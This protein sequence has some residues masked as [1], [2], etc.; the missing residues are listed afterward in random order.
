MTRQG[1]E[2]LILQGLTCP[3]EDAAF[4]LESWG[5]VQGAGQRQKRTQ[6]QAHRRP[7]VSV[8]GIGLQGGAEVGGCGMRLIW[9][10][11]PGLVPVWPFFWPFTHAEAS[12]SPLSL[13]PHLSQAGPFNLRTCLAEPL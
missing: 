6:L 9:V 5:T 11:D 1:T 8:W 2:E 12:V 10:E 3:R 4:P 13:H 7:L